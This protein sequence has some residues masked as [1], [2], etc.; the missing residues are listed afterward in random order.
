MSLSL[1]DITVPVMIRGMS[2]ASGV[3]ETGRTFARQ[4]GLSDEAV[5]GARLASDM[6]TL[7][8]QI[9][10]ASDMAKLTVVR[11]GQVSNVPMADTETT[12]D[13]A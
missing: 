4:N 11:I 10:R 9:Q 1:Y 12:F 7:M 2:H 13:E 5:L 6:M 3:L 8:G